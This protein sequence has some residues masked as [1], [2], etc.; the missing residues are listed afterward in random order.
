MN[1]FNLLGIFLKTVKSAQMPVKEQD[2]TNYEGNNKEL[3][4]NPINMLNFILVDQYETITPC[5]MFVIGK[6]G[7]KYNGIGASTFEISDTDNFFDYETYHAGANYQ[8]YRNK[9]LSEMKH[10]FIINYDLFNA[11]RIHDSN[12]VLIL[13]GHPLYDPSIATFYNRNCKDEDLIYYLYF[14]LIGSSYN[15]AIIHKSAEVKKLFCWSGLV[16]IGK[17]TKSVT[18][19]V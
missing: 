16:I 10:Q 6:L 4:L 19:C 3:S 11:C 9:I 5:F 17:D 7:V 2:M 15:F 1:Y 13:D 8:K 14:R 18:M 12:W